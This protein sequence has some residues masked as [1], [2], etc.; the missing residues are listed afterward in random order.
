M[1]L[2]LLDY[3]LRNPDT[4]NRMRLAYSNCH[5]GTHDDK[6]QKFD[7]EKPIEIYLN[8]HDNNACQGIHLNVAL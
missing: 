1:N 6:I 5:I 3:P 8:N 7:L 2:H 4:I